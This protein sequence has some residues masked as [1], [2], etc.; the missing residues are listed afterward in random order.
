VLPLSTSVALQ[1]ST[2]VHRSQN[3]EALDPAAEFDGDLD[4]DQDNELD[5]ER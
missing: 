1:D 4:L 3:R 5:F 2:S